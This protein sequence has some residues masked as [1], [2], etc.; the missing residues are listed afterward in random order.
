MAASLLRSPWL[1]VLG[2]G[3]ALSVTYHV[4]DFIWL[5]AGPAPAKSRRLSRYLHG[6][7][8][9]WALV[10]GA[11]DGIGRALSAEL[12]RQGFNVVLHGRNA[13]KLDAARAALS[14]SHPG[15]SFRI[16]VADATSPSLY[17]RP[18]DPDSDS[19]DPDPFD[20]LLA[21]LA[22]L[23]LTVLVNNAGGGPR[24]TF[25]FLESYP[26]ADIVANLRLNAGF[27]TL[28]SA[29]LIPRLRR[30]GPALLLNVASVSDDG[31]PLLSFY[32]AA[33]AAAH[34]V[35]VAIARE[36][37]MRGEGEG[38][39]EVLSHRI[40]AVTGVSRLAEE[41]SL[42]RPDA[43]VV[44]RAILAKTGCGRSVVVPYWPHALQ[45]VMMGLF[46]AGLKERVLIKAMKEQAAQQDKKE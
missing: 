23:N 29:A 7:T 18:S 9:A 2:A 25:G 32:G 39:L 44:A 30:R 34:V 4:L 40:G 15:R 37:R 45:Q 13:E 42:F 5:Y 43:G 26:R 3:L 11:S 14:A 12:A 46:P 27:P 1:S 17:D 16:L 6:D 21:P 20:A 41:P 38:E 36:A 31:V 10:T 35:H 19:D 22:D 28:L 24:P 33:K 8:P